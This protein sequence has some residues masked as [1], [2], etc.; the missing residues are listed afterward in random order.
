M[1]FQVKPRQTASIQKLDVD[2]GFNIAAYSIGKSRSPFCNYRS[3]AAISDLLSVTGEAL[4]AC[5]TASSF[6]MS[7]LVPY[8]EGFLFRVLDRVTRRIIR[9]H[10]I[11]PPARGMDL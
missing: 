4:K 6:M 8:V 10:S 5:C 3:S 2:P 11:V 1:A 7:Y 9:W